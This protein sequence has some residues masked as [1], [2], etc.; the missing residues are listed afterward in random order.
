MTAKFIVSEQ[1]TTITF[2]YTAITD[3]MI[4]V[5]SDCSEYLWNLGYGDHGTIDKPKLFSSL[6]NQQKLGLVDTHLRLVVLD[7][8][9]ANKIARAQAVVRATE[10]STKY[11][12]GV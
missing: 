8:A 10:E 5:I 9:N 4:Y 2:E 3:K 12:V 6:T 1:N 11:S 7:A